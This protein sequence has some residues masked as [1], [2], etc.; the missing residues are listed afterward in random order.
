MATI[1]E[2][3]ELSMRQARINGHPEFLSTGDKVVQTERNELLW[4]VKQ[5]GAD[6]IMQID[7]VTGR[8]YNVPLVQG[9]KCTQD[10]KTQ[11]SDYCHDCHAVTR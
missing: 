3:N 2:A 7:K 6:K 10:G 5:N 4:S 9:N 1:K 8:I 11:T